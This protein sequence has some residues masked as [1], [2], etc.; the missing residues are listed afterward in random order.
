[1]SSDLIYGKK[2]DFY[3]NEKSCERIFE[4]NKSLHKIS[5]KDDFD[6]IFLFNKYR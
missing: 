3:R 2:I 5:N 6:Y 1:M 4:N